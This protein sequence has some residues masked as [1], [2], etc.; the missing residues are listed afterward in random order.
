MNRSK[1]KT[2]LVAYAAFLTL[3]LPAS[4]LGV[5]WP[6]MRAEFSLQLDAMGLV[7]MIVVCIFGLLLLYLYSIVARG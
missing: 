4:L 2:L 1:R 3:G 6:T 7:L 5:A